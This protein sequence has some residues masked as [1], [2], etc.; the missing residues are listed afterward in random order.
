MSKRKEEPRRCFVTVG[1]TR[2][3]ALIN[4]LYTRGVRE[5]LESIG[6][7]EL[8]IQH[9]RSPIPTSTSTTSIEYSMFDYCSS[10]EIAGHFSAAD[11]VISHAGAGSLFEALSNRGTRVIAVINEA[12]MDNH[13]EELARVLQ[14]HDYI[15]AARVRNL[16]DI[17]A[18]A[19]WK[20]LAALPERDGG[21][22]GSVVMQEAA[23]LR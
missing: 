15:L 20:K 22:I 11:L 16:A 17:V 6:V 14:S 18:Q 10:A 21:I 3:D 7:R 4:A 23:T 2:F 5:A 1:T 19:G 9:G 13:Q 12:L 8:H